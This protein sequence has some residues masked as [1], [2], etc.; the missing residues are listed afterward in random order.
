MSDPTPQRDP[1]FR[2]RGN[3]YR[4]PLPPLPPLWQQSIIENARLEAQRLETQRKLKT[5]SLSIA[6]ALVTG[7]F[8][9]SGPAQAVDYDDPVTG[10]ADN[11][12]DGGSGGYEPGYD[13]AIDG[14]GTLHYRFAGGDRVA[15]EGVDTDVLAMSV[16]G[17]N[18]PVALDVSGGW[19]ELSANRPDSSIRGQAVG[20]LNDGNTVTVNGNVRISANARDAD[21]GG[22]LGNTAYAV[23]GRGGG[24]T[25]FN[26]ATDLHARTQGFA[27]AVWVSG[28]SSVVFNGPT[29][30]LAESRGTLDAV[31]NSDGG[32]ITFNGDTSI[33]ALS[34]WPSDNAHAIYND[35]VNTRLTVNGDLSLTTVAAGSTAFGVRNQGD[36][37]VFGDAIVSVTGPRSTHGIANT[38]RSAWMR[39]HGD[40][41]VR[42]LSEGPENGYVPF[43]NP[44]GLSNDRSPGAVMTFDGA[45]SVDVASEAET[46]GL[47]ST[48]FIEFTSPTAPVS[49]SVAS[50][51]DC[52]ACDVYGIRN[53]GTVD[54][55]GGLI[56]STS[57]SNGGAAYSIW[58]VPLDIQDASITVNQAGGQRVQ[59][60]GDVATAA[61]SVNGNIGSVD[62]D[63][64]TSDSWLRGLVGGVQTDGSYSVGRADLA[65]ANGAAWMPQGTGT[66]S[67]DIGAGTL[68]LGN[69]GTIDMAAHWGGFEPGAVPAHGHR[70]LVVDSSTGNGTVALGDGARFLL[71]SDITGQ[72]GTATADR[73]VFG[74]G[75]ASFSATGTQGVGIVYDP[76]LDDTSW[77]NDETLRDGTTIPALVPIDIVDASAAAGGEAAFAGA[78]GLDGQWSATYENALV[79]FT[80]T[81][82]VALGE[83]GDTIALTGI[84]IRGSGDDDGDG[85]DG[86][87][88]DG[89]DGGTGDGDGGETGNGGDGDTG[90]GGGGD[91]V[92]A[93]TPNGIQPSETVL[94]AAEAVDSA[95]GL[96]TF[97]ESGAQRRMQGLAGN[98]DRT[99]TGAWVRVDGGRL[100]ADAAYARSHRQDYSGVSAGADR[101]F[102]L[103]AGANFTGFN[104]GRI[105]SDADYARGQGELTGT[106][107][108]LYSAWVADGGAY[109]LVGA[110][111]A[112]LENRYA[113][114]DST[115]ANIRGRYETRAYRL[116]AEGGYPFHLARSWYIEPQLG[117]SVGA[118]DGSDHTTS[119]G[120]RIAHDDYDVSFARAGA[121]VGRTLQGPAL[122]G[123]VYLRAAARHDFGDDLR[124]AASRDGG[125]IVP[126]AADRTGTG[127]EFAA[128][129]DLAIGARAGL[130]FEASK[131]SGE[132]T[133]R[134]WGAQAGFRYNW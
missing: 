19:L 44:S 7:A 46:Y 88:G 48:G 127:G 76:V 14:D 24:T 30:I 4:P 67:N 99:Q 92:D 25:V 77:V 13:I 101:R 28:G 73:V 65:F 126:E 23:I 100:T 80:Y 130:F 36:M 78:A 95:V 40:V 97:A 115:G 81:P 33:S 87:T 72:S 116:H 94:T 31:Y 120:V 63:F 106:T 42:V 22:G 124:I 62:L 117:L 121:A 10:V 89:G 86:D 52:S 2:A 111:A 54:V 132:G 64:D 26:G 71:L 110:E 134:D 45:V 103:D 41:D 66:L 102:A 61:D 18:P 57:P 1:R 47:V 125:S 12:R 58:S 93:G 107:L 32:T 8:V 123:R 59:L 51:S 119:N 35:N 27:R 90:D 49:F 112:S 69:G 68:T 6:A 83:D 53:F 131:A 82:Q 114:I 74:G 128:G 5:L 3:E 50:T 104:V 11:D 109:V 133:G 70:T 56:V 39:W 108:G 43:G 16:T 98:G 9:R 96:W 21:H 38:H 34:I 113:S 37:E 105:R 20:I 129:A 79:Q 85:G 60:D 29:T 75:I 55:V 122:A 118:V 17:G 84:E 91:D 15:L